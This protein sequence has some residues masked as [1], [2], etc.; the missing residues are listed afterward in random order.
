MQNW[1]HLEARLSIDI[2]FCLQTHRKANKQ[3]SPQGLT[4]ALDK[5]LEAATSENT[6]YKTIDVVSITLLISL[7]GRDTLFNY[8]QL[9][10]FVNCIRAILYS[11]LYQKGNVCFSFL[12]GLQFSSA[13]LLFPPG[14]FLLGFAF[15][16]GGISVC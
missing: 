7:V 12:D 2:S 10:S 8:S 16:L 4:S 11:S 14:A 15:P 3:Q 9:M 1:T 6:T 13:S 5:P